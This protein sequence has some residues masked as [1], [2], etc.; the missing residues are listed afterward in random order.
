M[1]S[2]VL[3]GIVVLV[4]SGLGFYYLLDR[5]R[6]QECRDARDRCIEA[7]DRTRDIALGENQLKRSL[8]QLQLTRDLLDCR[9]DNT[10]NPAA[11]QQCQADRNAAAQA[12][13]ASLDASDNTI[14]TAREQ[15]V[16]RCRD[17]AR[18]CDDES[19]PERVTPVG[20]GGGPGVEISCIEGNNAPCFKEVPEICK[21]IT[22]PCDNCPETLCGD[23]QWSFE[24]ET[25]LEV[26]LVAATDPA[27]SPRVLATSSP[28]GKE[29][30]LG[31]PAGIKLNPGER[32]Y[33][34]FNSK[35]KPGAPVKAVLRRNK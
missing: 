13:L 5:I 35:D 27:K 22:G 2:A 12:Q 10:G 33:L 16:T 7:C 23:G 28:K 19:Q 25:P 32:L 4:I 9:L 30:V 26:T 14:R 17:Q 15:C 20:G 3:V 24:S 31:I 6:S 21:V 29:A 11:I 8:I 18:E 1:R 34:G